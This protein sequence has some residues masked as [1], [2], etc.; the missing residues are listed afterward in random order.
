MSQWNNGE[1]IKKKYIN[2]PEIGPSL[3]CI[4]NKGEKK[5]K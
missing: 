2:K 4:E 5:N 1:R 3:L